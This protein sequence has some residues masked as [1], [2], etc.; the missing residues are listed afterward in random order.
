MIH[1]DVVIDTVD[2]IHIPTEV[3]DPDFH[4]QTFGILRCPKADLPKRCE[5]GRNDQKS[6]YQNQDP[7]GFAE[8]FHFFEGEIEAV[9]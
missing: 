6:S 3:V 4:I 9:S 2:L 1:P 5:I 8:L 7:V